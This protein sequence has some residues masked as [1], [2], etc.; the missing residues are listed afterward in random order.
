MKDIKTLKGIGE[1]TA[2]RLQKLGIFYAEDLLKHYPIRYSQYP[3]VG[4]IDFDKNEQKVCIL[5]RIQGRVNTVNAGKYR[6]SSLTITDN[7][8]IIMAK[9]Y[10]S[11]YIPSGL[12][13]YEKYVFIG[14]Q[15]K[16]K[17][18]TYLEHPLVYN[19]TEYK[20][21]MDTLKPIYSLTEGISNSFFEKNIKLLFD[22]YIQDEEDFLPE[23]IKRKFEL[24]DINKAKKDIHTARTM[25][26][27]LAA[28][29]RLVFDE[30][31][32]FIYNTR[33]IKK[34]RS[35]VKSD[36]IIDFRKEYFKEYS[37]LLP[38]ELTASQKQV[39]AELAQDLSN[40][41]IMNR[42][43][44]GDVGSG[45]TVIAVFALFIV[46][47]SG[48]QGAMMA[49]TEVLARQHYNTVLKLFDG[50]DNKPE[51]ALLTGSMTAKEHRRIY[52]RILRHEVDI[53]IG[54]HAIIQEKV[55]FKKLALVIT[56]EQHRFGVRQR[57]LL[58]GKGNSPHILVMSATPIPRTLAVILYGELDISIVNTKPA[59]RLAIKNCVITKTDRNKAYAHIKKE[60]EKGHQAYIICAMV[61]SN[62]NTDLE[63]VIDYS[64][65]IKEYFGCEISVD[66]LHGKMQQSKKDDIMT[67][68]IEKKIDIL[69]S[70]T[71]IEVGIDVPNATVIMIEDAQRFGLASLH[72]LRGR[73]GR[74]AEQ[75]Y[76]IFVSTSTS[77][78]AKKRL[79]IVGN[80]N[81]GFFIAS[82][83]LKLRGPGEI[84][85]MAQSG[86][87]AFELADIYSDSSVMSM[88]ANAVDIVD[89]IN[90]SKKE[91]ALLEEK[92]SSYIR[93]NYDKMSL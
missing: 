30:F 81:D 52:E 92:L 77:K 72:Q 11:P 25:E 35:G 8:N 90:L 83:D 38:F 89:G 14:T 18:I 2:K 20:N 32:L 66:F 57:Q 88:A 64:E 28:R 74:G 4:E 34:E 63:N 80:S 37:E 29:K 51:I 12:N 9:W 76:C 59:N 16:K 79:D 19:Y 82:E 70:T 58:A 22:S 15:T 33:L 13:P 86:E 75:S 71:V 39:M 3:K 93:Y 24:I 45:K 6:I 46:V 62:E 36:Y 50:M 60:I 85:G 73:V 84:F 31:F 87:L 67:R 56:D 53:V 21:I 78:D 69:V 5:G 41:F 27:V 55:E 47:R 17:N 65:K 68:F 43:I 23:E 42:L 48:Y 54:T 49:P 44:Q 26:E 7:K 10:N 40:N 1:K 91:R 61:E